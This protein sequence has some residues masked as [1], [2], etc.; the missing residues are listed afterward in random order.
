MA[1]K[2]V[3]ELSWSVSRDHLFQ[4]CERA[5][6]Y[7]Y[8]GSW[9]GWESDAPAATRKLYILK[10]HADPAMW[11]GGV[12]HGV[13]AE[14]LR[15]HAMKRSPIN[16]AELKAHAREKL[17]AGWLE[18]V[19]RD[20]EATPKKT[21]LFELYYGNGRTLPA[22][23]TERIKERVNSCLDAFAD[24]A[25]LREILAA[26][27][28][29]W[30]PVEQLDS[31]LLDGTLK[32]WCVIDFAFSDPAGWLRILDWKTGGE[33]EDSL[34][35][36]LACYALFAADKWHVPVERQRVAGVFL[37]EGARVSEYP[38][39]PTT[40]I[41][42]KDRVLTSAAAM[43]GKLAD[44]EANLAREE[45]FSPCGKPWVCAGCNYREVCPGV[46]A[47]STA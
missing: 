43:R 39:E 17:R 31:F 45:G 23:E 22:E 42:A 33:R 14:A 35:L 47:Q 10:K 26:S 28:L 34:Q 21:N 38:V 44:V 3:N 40:L 6:Y 5:Y 13:I 25:I 37:R 24:S 4:S 36:Q 9:G 30:R 27:Y 2:L 11:A 15:R 20:W 8:Y 7:T 46:T 29:S 12:V 16:A 32:V 18:A 19:N 1:R 41:E